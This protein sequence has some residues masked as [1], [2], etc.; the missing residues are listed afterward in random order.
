MGLW[1]SPYY[2]EVADNFIDSDRIISGIENGHEVVKIDY[3]TNTEKTYTLKK[4]NARLNKVTRKTVTFNDLKMV[5]LK[6]DLTGNRYDGSSIMWT[7]TKL[8]IAGESKKKC[9]KIDKDTPWDHSNVI[10]TDFTVTEDWQCGC[11]D[12]STTIGQKAT[13]KSNGDYNGYSD[14][15]YDAEN[16]EYKNDWFKSIDVET[17]QNN[18]SKALELIP[19][20]DTFPDGLDLDLNGLWATVQFDYESIVSMISFTFFMI[21]ILILNLYSQNFS[22]YKIFYI[23]LQNE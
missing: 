2:D 12:V 10:A 6:I 23:L 14:D 3:E 11:L 9:V 17:V 20:S 4:T 21:L 19:T 7:G 5:P 16:E 8:V 13:L 1:A 15:N 22:S 18:V